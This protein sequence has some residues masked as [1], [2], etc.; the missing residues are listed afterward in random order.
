[1]ITNNLIHKATKT[2]DGE[3]I[4]VKIS[5]ND[6]CKNGHQ[7]FSI[8]ATIWEANKPKIDKYMIGG[9]CCHD[10]I[11]KHFPEFQIFVDLHLCDYSG[12]P[13]HATANGFYHLKK[14]GSKEFVKYFNINKE[15]Y[16]TIL[17]AEDVKH[18][19]YLVKKSGIKNDWLKLA[20][21][22]IQTLE[23]LTSNTFLNDSQRSQF[24][25]LT[26]EE[27]KEVQKRIREG[28][29]LEDEIIKRED[30]RKETSKKHTINELKEA[31]KK[32]V[33][34]IMT[35]LAIKLYLLDYGLSIDNIIYYTHTNTLKFNWLDYKAKLSESDFDK[36]CKSFDSQK[37]PNNITLILE[38]V[39]QYTNK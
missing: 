6:E 33:D 9:G 3:L 31:A 23:K 5:L 38:G 16:K 37:L 11:L 19:T 21:K 28:Y 7:D 35:E 32:D 29:Y 30:E 34:K 18:F 22:G 13:M 25:D 36:F 12:S 17:I 39:K 24:I 27:Q 8:T 14:M 2:A 4:E 10:D 20:K 15:Q 26:K 1:M